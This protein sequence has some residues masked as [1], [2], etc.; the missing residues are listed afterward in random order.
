MLGSRV[1]T[2]GVV[3]CLLAACGDSKNAKPPHDGVTGGSGGKSGAGGG[4]GTSVGGTS[5]SGAVATGGGA[6][7]PGGGGNA[8][9]GTAGSA[10]DAGEAG[11]ASGGD[12]SG[13]SAGASGAGGEGGAGALGIEG[14]YTF[15]DAVQNTASCDP[16]GTSVRGAY[17]ATHLVVRRS[18]VAATTGDRHALVVT[19][20][21]GLAACRALG[22][23]LI[24]DPTTFELVPYSLF[25]SEGPAGT[26]IATPVFYGTLD[27]MTCRDGGI[28]RVSVSSTG[29]ALTQETRV[30]RTDYPAV[31]GACPPSSAAQQGAAAPCT[32][33][34]V[35]TGTLVETF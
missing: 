33:L 34:S 21:A 5:G 14:I 12:P 22:A 8:S 19:G 7:S 35:L 4:A 29:A 9:G 11:D 30:H 24:D 28:H 27:G 20:C 32:Q 13:G 18:T 16:G 1:L 23:A 26:F 25:T 15:D 2:W 10:G 6:G 31:A 17:A 3:G